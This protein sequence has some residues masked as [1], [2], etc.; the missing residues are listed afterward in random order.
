MNRI[1]LLTFA[2][3]AIACAG[4]AGTPDTDLGLSKTSVFDAPS[5]DPV[6]EERAEPGEKPPAPRAYAG[7]PPVIP[8]EVPEFLPITLEQ[9]AC[10]DCHMTEEKTPGEPT[11]IPSSH[12]VDLRNAPAEA[13]DTIAGARHV[14]V[15]CHVARS[16]A[17]PLVASR[18]SD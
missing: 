16:E 8:H 17:Q 13:R 10:L 12:Y 11:P 4:P 9:N 14:C 1:I 3:A 2:A 15:T 7:S 5:P 6:Q 18:F